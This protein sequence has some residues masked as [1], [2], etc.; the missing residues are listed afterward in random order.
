M[1]SEKSPEK[2]PEKAPEKKKSPVG[3]KGATTRSAASRETPENRRQLI[4]IAKRGHRPRRSGNHPDHD[5]RGGRDPGRATTW[6]GLAGSRRWRCSS[7]RP[8]MLALGGELRGPNSY[9]A[10][11]VMDIPVL[12]TRGPDGE[13][14]AFVNQCSHRSAIVVPEGTGTA[15]RFACP[16]HNWTYNPMGDLVGVTD[17]EYFGEIDVECMGL[18]PLPVAERAG[19]IF[20]VITPGVA[21]N[22]DEHLCR[23]RPGARLLRLRRLAPRVPPGAGRAELEDRLRRLPRL[24]PPALP[25]PGQ[26]RRRTCTTRRSTRLGSAPADDPPGPGLA[27]AAATSPRTSG[28]SI[29]SAAACGRS[30]PTSRSPAATAAARWPSCS[31]ARRPTPRGR[32]S[33]TTWRPSPRRSSGSLAVEQAGVRRAR[34]ARRGLLHRLGHPAGVGERRQAIGLFGRNEGGGQRFHRTLD[35]YIARDIRLQLDA[36][37]TSGRSIGA[38]RPRPTKTSRRLPPSRARRPS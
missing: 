15:R 21:M 31:R 8:L 12:L 6:T 26:L 1:S 14:R 7:G 25:A 36:D 20:V 13:V 16:Y 11:T 17:R 2:T 27:R 3:L 9:K 18:T 10:M 24:L 22:I 34:R 32:S 19:L 37:L 38:T 33:T 29:R 30:S 35:D 28:T 5:R 23:V 4:D